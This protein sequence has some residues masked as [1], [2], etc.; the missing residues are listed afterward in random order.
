MRLS[1]SA[2]G[3]SNCHNGRDD[4]VPTRGNPKHHSWAE[5]DQPLFSY[6]KMFRTSGELQHRF[7]SSVVLR[8][9]VKLQVSLSY[10]NVAAWLRLAKT[11]HRVSM[12]QFVF[13]WAR[14]IVFV[15]KLAFR[16]T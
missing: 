16:K 6:L 11:I 13:K 14:L 3:S 5:L 4:A 9:V 8:G 2:W 7:R 1:R 15:Q 12:Q 10:S